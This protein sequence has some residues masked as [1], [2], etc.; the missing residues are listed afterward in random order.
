M[1]YY[2]PIAGMSANVFVFLGLGGA[3]GFLSGL[4]GVG[5]GFLMTPLLIF[6]GIPSVIA[7]GT[8]AAQIVASSVSGAVAQWRRRNVDIKLGTVLLVGGV[9]GSF[10]GVEMVKI[11][12]RLGQFDIVLTLSYVTFLGVIG[13]LM[14]IESYNAMRKARAG[15]PVSTR[16]PG[17]HSWIHGLPFKMRF[18]RSKLYISAIPPFLIGAFV[19]LLMAIMGV[20]GGFIMVPAMVY[21]LRMPTNV[22]VGTSLFQIVFVT[23]LTTVLQATNNYSVDIVLA[24]LLIVGGVVGTQF[25]IVAGQKLKG[26]QLRFLLAALVLLVCFRVAFS[27]VATPSDLYS[28]SPVLDGGI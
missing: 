16:R 5:G 8:E 26:E 27:L 20:G 14:L 7:V 4:F 21:L 1:Q 15:T 12:R 23:A 2:L 24:I 28:I 10:V 22:V 6:S 17:Q 19:G 9:A 3:V 11:L 18:H 13:A 25:G